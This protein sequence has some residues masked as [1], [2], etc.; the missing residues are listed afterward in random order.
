[1]H[2]GDIT[3][4][5]E[6]SGVI[7]VSLTGEHD[8]STAPAL[9]ERL[10]AAL[11]ERTPI[12]VN[13]SAAEFI[14]SSII[15]VLLDLHRRA[16]EAGIGFATALEDGAPPVRRVLEITGLDENLPIRDSAREAIQ[17]AAAGREGGRG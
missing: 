4:E 3:V 17:T 10:E 8:L 6:D 12:V 5:R 13:L 14:D 16:D 2:P 15:G 11:D 1:V 9:R 7:V